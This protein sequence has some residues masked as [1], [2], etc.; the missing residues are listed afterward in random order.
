[1][2]KLTARQARWEFLSIVGLTALA[3]VLRF[4]YLGSLPP[5]LYHDEAYNGLDALRVLGGEYPVFFEANNGREPLFIYL[6]ALTVGLLGRTPGALRLVSAVLGTLTV[7]ATYEM[8]RSLWGKHRLALWTSF[9]VAVSVWP[10]NLSRIAFR[11]VSLPLVSALMLLCLWRGLERRRLAWMVAAGT[12]CGVALYTYLAARLIPVV[13]LLY[14]LVVFWREGRRFWW[15]GW[16]LFGFAAGLVALPI[17]FYWFTHWETTLARAGQVSIW[18]PAIGGPN[19]WRTLALNVVRVMLG[20]VWRGDFIPRHNVPLR[21]VF[22]PLSGAVFLVG[23]GLAVRRARREG[24]WALCLIWLGVLLVP[25]LLAE[26]APHFIR[27]SGILPVVFV[28]P[29]VGLEALW[30]W[31]S[32]KW[33]RAALN[34]FVGSLLLASAVSGCAAYWRHVHSEAAYY[35]F[36]TGAVTLAREMNVAL[37]R[38]WVGGLREPPSEA[39]GTSRQVLVAHRLW[40]NWANVRFL[41]PQGEGLGILTAEGQAPAGFR[42]G[43]DVTLF[44][45]PFEDRV[46]A[47]SALPREAFVTVREGAYERG[48]LEPESRLLYVVIRG[49]ALPLAP[50][51][52]KGAPLARWQRGMSLVYYAREVR[53]GGALTLRLVWRAEEAPNGSWTIFRHIVCDGHL[54]GQKDGP[55][56]Q[57]YYP[58]E[59]WRVGDV[60]EDVAEIPLSEP[61]APGRCEMRVG[62]YHWPSGERLVLREATLPMLDETTVVMR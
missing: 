3:A 60:I 53:P 37:G 13:I 34:A 5:G 35:Q 59:L 4:A 57:G 7:P 30:D 31:L 45:W 38:G 46:A 10:L 27:A 24:A 49:Q 55:P 12:F 47:L 18:N 29:A 28:F 50:D 44:L 19:P 21:P 36:E 16:A 26:D 17:V 6:C 40:E 48:D 1:M 14:A 23:L 54:V 58:T 25:T 20:F 42:L 15:A 33:P 39:E 2:G 56:A 52:A 32:P 41:V 9:F 11:A 43:S 62:W 22:D 61:F 51:E 8:V